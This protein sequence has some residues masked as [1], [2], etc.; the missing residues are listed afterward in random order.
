MLVQYIIVRDSC[1]DE[2]N[3]SLLCGCHLKDKSYITLWYHKAKNGM[4]AIIL[5]VLI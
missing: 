4:K 3:R 5:I 1:W 2:N